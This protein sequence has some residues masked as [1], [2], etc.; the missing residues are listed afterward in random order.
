MILLPSEFLKLSSNTPIVDVRTPA[1]FLQ[2]H[3]PGAHNI[4]LFTNEERAIIGTLYKQV[5]KEKAVEKGL[6]IVGPKM[7]EYVS[8]AKKIAEDK[9]LLVHCWRG[10]MRSS[11]MAWLFKTSGLDAHTL[12]GGYKAYR[13]FNMDFYQKP[14]KMLILG[15]K[16]GSGK[17]P[18]LKEISKFGS[19]VIDLEGISHHKGSAFGFIG[20]MTQ[21]TNEQFENDLAHEWQKLNLENTIWLED[22]SQHIGHVFMP[23]IFYDYIR[24]SNLIFIDVPKALRIKRLVGEYAGVNNDDLFIA[25][26][27]IQKRLGGLNY[28]NALAALKAGDF[29]EVASITLEYYD[30]AYM[31]GL[32]ARE[33]KK[34]HRLEIALEDENQAAGA[35]LNF[36]AKLGLISKTDFLIQ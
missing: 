24:S 22:E 4:P 23:K 16:T 32:A 2:G 20:Q 6:E 34:V 11:S 7:L 15:G 18:I 8:N 33:T 10:G 14:S 26:E 12:L 5:G 30:K 13:R 17:T 19:Q 27:K 36:A 35:V 9:K 29:G 31:F 21:P 28:K 25:L 1:E 3:I